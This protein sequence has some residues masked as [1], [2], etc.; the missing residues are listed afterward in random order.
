MASL[1]DLGSYFGSA[2]GSYGDAYKAGSTAGKMAGSYYDKYK[3][4]GGSK[5]GG[6]NTRS[7]SSDHKDSGSKKKK[8]KST[9]DYMKEAA[10]KYRKS[11]ESNYNAAKT[12]GQ[13]QLATLGEMAK[14]TEGDIS[15]AITGYKGQVENQRQRIT[16]AVE[17]GIGKARNAAMDV[18]RSNRNTLRGLGILG[19][20]YAGEKMAAPLSAF[21]EQRASLVKQGQQQINELD[22]VLNTK[23]A[24]L[25]SQLNQAKLKFQQ[26]AND[27]RSDIRF[28]AA[29]RDQ[30]LAALSQSLADKIAAARTNAQAMAQQVAQMKMNISTSIASA[31]QQQNPT[32]DFGSLFQ[33]GMNL[34]NDMFDQSG[35]TAAM[36]GE[37][38]KEKNP[39]AYY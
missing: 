33:T 5:S 10:E 25:T 34:T 9:E 22:T 31:M 13:E 32:A 12:R 24:E 35:M 37:D 39:L 29:E 15:N 7:S 20:T 11:L 16:G 19:S 17:E 30:A 27:I 1:S 3:S 6:S 2:M 28:T 36:Y 14:L 38:D 18:Q 4:N 26:M 21:S 8:G 23:V